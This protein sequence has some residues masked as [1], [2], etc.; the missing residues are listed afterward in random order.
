MYKKTAKALHL[1]THA[2]TIQLIV[3]RSGFVFSAKQIQLNESINSLRLE[4]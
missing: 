4:E 1:S 3:L 2:K